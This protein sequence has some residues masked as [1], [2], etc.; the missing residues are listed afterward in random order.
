ME[1]AILGVF[2]MHRGDPTY[3]YLRVATTA[4]FDP[5]QRKFDVQGLIIEVIV[6]GHILDFHFFGSCAL[7]S[8]K[9]VRLFWRYGRT[10][11]LEVSQV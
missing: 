5:L 4:K 8:G 3:T 2:K 1:N 7:I 11:E 6:A 10:G 9:F